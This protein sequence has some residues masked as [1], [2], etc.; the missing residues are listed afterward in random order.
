MAF[1]CFAFGGRGLDDDDDDDRPAPFSDVLCGAAGPTASAVC[2]FVDEQTFLFQHAEDAAALEAAATRSSSRLLRGAPS[3]PR[4]SSC[5]SL[6]QRS[7]RKTPR[8]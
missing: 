4:L 6:R 7:A 2:P 1:A 8:C 3:S 5:I